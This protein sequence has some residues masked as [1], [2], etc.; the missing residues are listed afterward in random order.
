MANKFGEIPISSIISN[1]E[2]PRKLFE[3]GKIKELAESIKSEGLIQPIIVRSLENGKFWLISGERR[4]RAFKHL[5]RIKIPAVIQEKGKDDF[6]TSLIENIQRKDLTPTEEA[7]AYKKL[8]DRGLQAKELAKKIGKSESLISQKLALL[9]LSSRVIRYLDKGVLT[10]GHG[11]QLLR[12]GNI[13]NDM[14]TTEVKD[15]FEY[16]FT[17][18]KEFFQIMLIEE[19]RPMGSVVDFTKFVD[20]VELGLALVAVSGFGKEHYDPKKPMPWFCWLRH[21]LKPET[22]ENGNRA[23]KQIRMASE[24]VGKLT[25]SE[26]ELT[27]FEDELTD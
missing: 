10:E 13:V 6:I 2:Q 17:D 11:R 7:R 20:K 18:W 22:S 25:S 26:G 8:I 15:Y 5:K 1:P 21:L 12:L 27:E 16:F 23:E 9:N 24:F 14:A 3:N 19:F 4:L